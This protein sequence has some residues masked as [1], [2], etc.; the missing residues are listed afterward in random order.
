MNTTV[1]MWGLFAEGLL[2][3]FSPCVLPLIPL[4][5]GYLTS[6]IDPA[7]MSKKQARMKT[8]LVTLFFMLG[9]STV[10]I[11]AALGAN[12][13][14][15]FFQQKELMFQ[16]IGGILLIVFGLFSLGVIDLPWLNREH[17]MNM[18]QKKM[19]Y[20]SAYLLGFFFSF[21]WSPCIGPMLG[22]AIVMSANATTAA[23][24]YGYIA[25]FA[26]GFLLMFLLVGLFTEEMLQ[27]F[28]KKQN[29]VKYTEI[30]GAVIIIVMGVM[31]SYRA[32][33]A[34]DIR[35]SNTNTVVE[36]TNNENVVDSTNGAV[37]EKKALTIEDINFTL[38]NAEGEEVSLT[39]YKGDVV[40]INFFGTWCPYCMKEM[41]M[42]EKIQRENDDVK[43][44]LINEPNNGRE[45]TIEQVE[46]Y[47]K[48]SG[49]H[50]E[51][52]YD[53][54]GS[55]TRSFGVRGFPTSYFVKKD[56]ELLGYMPSYIQ[57]DMWENILKQARGEEAE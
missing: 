31:M 20:W 53:E 19:S 24:G 1:T 35:N 47:M 5:L 25:S 26:A 9:I 33:S 30:I 28:K 41:P 4:Y 7:T 27:F 51:I 23:A 55:I 12:A 36:T 10:F 6:D 14:Q 40:I 22:S 18:P 45:G 21:A 48:E 38:K 43:V 39:D 52:L 49:Y 16:L 8:L 37:E 57:D 50:L 32:M 29:V 46:S 3:F 2:A 13:L 34:I 44:L 11:L 42:I 17:R 15:T 54:D 56:G